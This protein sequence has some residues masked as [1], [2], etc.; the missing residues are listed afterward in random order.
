MMDLRL[1]T[2]SVFVVILYMAIQG[3]EAEKHLWFETAPRE[4]DRCTN[5]VYGLNRTDFLDVHP[6]PDCLE[7]SLLW[8]GTFGKVHLHMFIDNSPASQREKDKKEFE[9]C[10][11][12][13]EANALYIF[14]DTT[15]NY[16][17]PLGFPHYWHMPPRNETCRPSHNGVV[18]L[19]I[20][21][22]WRIPVYM[23]F[24][25]WTIRRIPEDHVW[26]RK[27]GE[28]IHKDDVREEEEEEENDGEMGGFFDGIWTNLYDDDEEE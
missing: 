14:Y 2:C 12:K 27:S 24:L 5:V 11:I 18:D 19:Y 21:P 25:T 10:L 26:D 13:G 15:L 17:E 16:W 3:L 28:L 6:P 22:P 20:E 8:Y 23:G 9:I 7:G 1:E 4:D